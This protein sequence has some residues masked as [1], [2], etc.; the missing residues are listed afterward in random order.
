MAYDKKWVKTADG[1]YTFVQ[2]DTVLAEILPLKTKNDF[3]VRVGKERFKINASGALGQKLEIHSAEAHTVLKIEPEKWYSNV[4]LVHYH[5]EVYR[6]IIRNNPLCEFVIRSGHEEL[7][8]YGLDIRKATNQLVIRI[9]ESE[10]PQ[11]ILFHLALWY[12]FEP[13]A[14]ENSGDS[15]WWIYGL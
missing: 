7:L 6:L 1:N 3:N 8:A 2:N 11:P 10:T 15:F 9:T 14:R 5:N 12:L 4:F 13:V